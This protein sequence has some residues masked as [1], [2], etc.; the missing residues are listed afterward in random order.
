MQSLFPAPVQAQALAQALASCAGLV[1]ERL[2]DH[3]VRS[4][5]EPPTRSARSLELGDELDIVCWSWSWTWTQAGTFIYGQSM[6]QAPGPG[7][8]EKKPKQT[9]SFFKLRR[10]KSEK[11]FNFCQPNLTP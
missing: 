1:I 4:N 5:S 2:T 3:T 7:R 9:L 10:N 6:P 11:C 8:N